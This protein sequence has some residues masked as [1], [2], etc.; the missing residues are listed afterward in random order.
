MLLRQLH[1]HSLQDLLVVSL[2]SGEQDTITVNNDEAEFVVV[3]EQRQERLRL[4]TVLT[5]VG[6]DVDGA[7]RLQGDLDLPLR[8]AV[9]HQDDAA[10]NDQAAGWDVL[11]QL[12]LLSRG[13]DRGDDGLA[14]LTRFDGFSAGQLLSQKRHV[15][16][17]LIAGWDVQRDERSTVSEKENHNRLLALHRV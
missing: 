13:R 11:V 17:Q 15:L 6:E 14:R 2:E 3:L 1:W 10:E 5:P 4:K 12:E 9:L 16:V 8:V 7:E